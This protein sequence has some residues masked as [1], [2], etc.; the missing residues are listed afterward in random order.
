MIRVGAPA[1]RAPSGIFDNT[2]ELALILTR[3]VMEISRST[4]PPEP[5]D[6]LSPTVGR[7]SSLSIHN[8]LNNLRSKGRF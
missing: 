1:A 3:L 4:F 5:I 7:E 8:P 2:T 6:A